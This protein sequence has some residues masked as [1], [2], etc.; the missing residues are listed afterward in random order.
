MVHSSE[1]AHVF[2]KRM[3][4]D[5]VKVRVV[6]ASGWDCK[7]LQ[8]LKVEV[9]FTVVQVKL[10]CECV[11]C[12]GSRGSNMCR[13]WNGWMGSGALVVLA[14]AH[15]CRNCDVPMPSQRQ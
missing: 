10:G 1:G 2:F 9:L 3:I 14:W 4:R 12:G 13:E 11:T 8:M 5:G 15:A 7:Y 6:G